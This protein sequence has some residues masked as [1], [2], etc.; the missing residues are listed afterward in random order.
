M[1]KHISFRS[2]QLLSSLNGQNKNFFTIKEAQEILHES[3]EVAVRRLLIYMAQRG[4]LLR[5]KDG[6][7][8]LIPYEKNVEEYFPNWHLTA[9]AI[10]HPK[11]YY[12]GF[13]SALDIHGLITQPSLTEQIVTEKQIVPKNQLV[14]KVKFE[15]ITFN[16]NKFFGYERTWIDDFNK[17][18]CSDIEKTLIDC[19]YKPNYSGGISEIAKAIYKCREKIKPDKI[20]HYLEKFDA[21]V[22]YKRMGFLL[23]HLDILPAL[24]KEIQTKLTDS[25]TL[26]DPSL[27]KKGKHYSAWKIVDN[28][29]IESTLRSIGT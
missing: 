14:K 8:N 16:K 11:N 26:I 4:L 28:I 27:P 17:I 22:V 18:N 15:F 25:Y 5:I 24:T 20:I 3:G 9:E 1:K 23:Q 19:L 7:Y 6:L 29:D 13:Y 12:I 2:G 21:Q 10:V